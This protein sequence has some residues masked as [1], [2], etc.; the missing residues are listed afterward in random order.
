MTITLRV[1]RI[2][3]TTYMN[4]EIKCL[5][6]KRNRPL[7]PGFEPHNIV[8]EM[9]RIGGTVEEAK[10]MFWRNYL[11]KIKVKKEAKLAWRTVWG[12]KN[13]EQQPTGKELQYR[14]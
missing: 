8:A 9:Q 1:F 7:Q 4:D 11:E 14:S 10:R 12:H 6:K 3:E 2:N 13:K 5:M